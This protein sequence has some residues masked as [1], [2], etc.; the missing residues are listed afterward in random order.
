[1]HFVLQSFPHP[2]K[3]FTT[4]V[5]AA[6]LT[7]WLAADPGVA[8]DFWPGVLMGTLVAIMGWRRWCSKDSQR[9][10]RCFRFF[11]ITMLVW[12]SLVFV[13]QR[14]IPVIAGP[15][16]LWM[17]LTEAM[18]LEQFNWRRSQEVRMSEHRV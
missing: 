17:A 2:I 16:G 11:A 12:F 9:R 1:M 4:I 15:F 10:E 14:D 3:V 13:P 6:V 5:L 7:G 18:A 8:L